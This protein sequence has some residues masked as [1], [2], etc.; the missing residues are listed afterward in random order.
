MRDSTMHFQ[1]KVMESLVRDRM[2]KH[3][4]AGGLFAPDQHGFTKGKSCPTN[5]LETLEWWTDALDNGYGVNAI[6]LDYQK[7][8]DTVPI[9]RLV[10]KL[11]AYGIRGHVAEWIEELLTARRMRV[12]VRGTL[13]KWVSIT[14]GVPQGSV[15]G[16]LLFLIYVND[17][18]ESLKCT[19]KMF[20]DDT[21]VFNKIKSK[22]DS[23]ML[24]DDLD[25]LSKWSNDWLLRF[26][27]QKCKRMHMGHG[28][29]KYKYEMNGEELQET[30]AEKDL[31]V[32][33]Q[34]NLKPE[35]QVTTAVNKAMTVLKSIRGAFEN[36]DKETFHI[37]YRTY[38]RPHLEYCIQAWSPYYCKDI[39]RLENVQ[40]R[41]TKMV[42]GMKNL[43]YEERLERLNVMKLEE[44]RLRWRPN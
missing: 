40:R 37:T 13:S 4:E 18:P 42:N 23:L 20:A 14:S 17:I 27:V 28:N 44:R 25:S 3:M 31:G 32:W 16:P 35:K 19:S 29:E 1:C 36:Y 34:N 8:F 2:V 11:K 5:L 38:V 7:A 15:I 43:C 30:E 12:A 21:K 22:E 41:A 39:Q 6:Y 10:L 33:M 9:K 26:N 24:Q